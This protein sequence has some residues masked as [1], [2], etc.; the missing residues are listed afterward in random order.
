MRALS[1]AGCLEIWEL[2]KALHPLDRGLLAIESVSTEADRGTAADWPLGRRNRALA[3]LRCACFG[4]ALKGWTACDG[5]GEELEF[6]VDA[7]AFIAQDAPAADARI[8]SRGRVLRLPTSRDL[9]SVAGEKDSALAAIRLVERC[10]ISSDDEPGEAPPLSDEDVDAI[11]E[12]MSAR[13]P[14]SEILLHF[15]CPECGASFDR[16]LDVTAF[17]WSEIEGR[18]KRLLRDVHA[19]ATAYGWSEEE[20]LSLSPARRSFYL[21]MVQ[22]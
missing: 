1:H 7:S 18:A 3:E 4:P 10:T 2:G 19:L 20:I 17:V 16:P 15:D 14:L 22:A 8:R 11:G 21:A 9:A 12:A 13:D 6:N 5:C